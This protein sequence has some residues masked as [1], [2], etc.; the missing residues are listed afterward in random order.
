[1]KL[2][3]NKNKFNKSIIK[4]DGINCSPKSSDDITKYTCY[5]NN[6]LFELRDLWNARHMD[7]QIKT[8]KPKEIHSILK[9]NLSNVCDKEKCWINQN[10]YFG[11]ISDEVK[12]SFAPISPYTWLDNPNQWLSSHDIMNVMYQYEIAYPEFRFI[13]PT[14]IDFD[15]KK[16]KNKNKIKSINKNKNIIKENC[17]WDELCNFDLQKLMKEGIKK[18]GIIFNTHPHNKSGE[19]WIS[20]FINIEKKNILYFDSGG[21]K[22]PKE[23][24][25]LARRIQDQGKTLRPK[26]NF[27]FNTTTGVHHQLE[28][29]E[30]G[31]YSLF[32]IINMLEENV[33][34]RYLMNN[35]FRD[36]YIQQF[37]EVYFNKPM[38]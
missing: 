1:M 18:I 35:L 31:I 23:I 4:I 11:S 27:K 34:K 13:G 3:E 21:S 9:Q 14:P 5:T 36:K 37:R 33:N 17:V 2:N 28:D 29:T 25:K 6:A 19:H 7:S 26:I 32:F 24:E 38:K 22:I 12:E 30:C 20:M 16:L 15:K 10:S 8:N